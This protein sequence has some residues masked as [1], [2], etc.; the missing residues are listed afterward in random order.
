MRMTITAMLMAV[1]GCSSG[2]EAPMTPVLMTGTVPPIDAA[3]PAKIE[4]VTFAVG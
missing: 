3:A 1:L 4:T 2:K